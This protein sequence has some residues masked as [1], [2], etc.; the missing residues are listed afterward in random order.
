MAG[1][2][3]GTG[4]PQLL[5]DSRT[6]SPPRSIPNP[7]AASDSEEE[8][9]MD[10][11]ASVRQSLIR[12][13]VPERSKKGWLAHQSIFPPSSSSS[14]SGASDKNTEED[15]DPGE[16]EEM[17]NLNEPLVGPEAYQVTVPIRLHIYQ[18]RF[19]HWDEGLRTYRGAP[20]KS[21]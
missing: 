16:A 8:L 4:L 1:S 21:G 2:G 12:P 13:P 10:Q 11:V 5:P 6:A 9:D 3:S 7:Y 18:G 20:W 17:N 15:S 19:G 14:T